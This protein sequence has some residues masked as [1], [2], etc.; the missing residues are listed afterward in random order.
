MSDPASTAILF[1]SPALHALKRSQ[2][3]GLCK[4][5][6]LKANGKNSDLIYRLEQKASRLPPEM[7]HISSDDEV[8]DDAGGVPPG[9]FSDAQPARPSEQWEMVM[10]DI[11]E[12]DE[13]VGTVSSV[14]STLRT[15]GPSGEFGTNGSKCECLTRAPMLCG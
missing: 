8:S 4:Q 12:V 6:D 7:A 5:H 13:P 1:N 11:Q 3:V 15:K 14:N 9:A 10:E 2:L